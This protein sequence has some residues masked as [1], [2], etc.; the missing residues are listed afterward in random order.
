[1]GV[2]GRNVQN[3]QVILVC[4]KLKTS[5]FNGNSRYTYVNVQVKGTVLVK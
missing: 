3:I 4:I 5:F 2:E 1:M